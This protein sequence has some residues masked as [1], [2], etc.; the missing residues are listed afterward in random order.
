M[1]A[2]DNLNLLKITNFNRAI[3][4]W[5]VE[6][7]DVAFQPCHPADQQ[8]K[9]AQ[10]SLQAPEC[11]GDPSKEEY[12]PVVADTW[13]YGAVLFFMATGGEKTSPYDATR[14]S[15]NLEEEVQGAVKAVAGIV[16]PAGKELLGG[17]LKTNAGERIPHGFI[18]KSEWF[19]K[20][21]KVG[22]EEFILGGGF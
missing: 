17:L 14:Q 8:A 19:E 4:Y 16:E 6:E 1:P 3:I 5:S 9:D 22:F 7:N 13:S 2:N 18:G 21:K 15:A 20:A 12:D 10:G 11:Y